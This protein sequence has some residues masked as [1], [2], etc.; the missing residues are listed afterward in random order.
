MFIPVFNRSSITS[1]EDFMLQ[2]LKSYNDSYINPITQ[3]RD[4]SFA[5]LLNESLYQN[6]ENSKDL[7]LFLNT[8]KQTKNT[9]DVDLDAWL[10]WDDLKLYNS[11][12]DIAEFSYNPMLKELALF[13][14]PNFEELLDISAK[15]LGLKNR[16][17][18]L[19]PDDKKFLS[20]LHRYLNCN[21][22]F[23]EKIVKELKD[24]D[25]SWSKYVKFTT[26]KAKIKYLKQNPH[27]PVYFM[28]QQAFGYN[29][30]EPLFFECTDGKIYTYENVP[31]RIPKLLHKSISIEVAYCLLPI[32]KEFDSPLANSKNISSLLNEENTYNFGTSFFNRPSPSGMYINN[33]FDEISER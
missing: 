24:Y 19:S 13:N 22:Y 5:I 14:L 9:K 20:R 12:L 31:E 8:L 21:D 7:Q 27:F 15:M 1:I 23:S 30:Q 2:R 28:N 25:S 18:K 4:F 32:I 16:T 26:D 6:E 29:K 10:V 3:I 33:T 17:E 11:L